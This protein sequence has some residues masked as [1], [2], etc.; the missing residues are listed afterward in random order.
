M[1]G[2]HARHLTWFSGHDCTAHFSTESYYSFDDQRNSF[3]IYVQL[4]CAACPHTQ[5]SSGFDPDSGARQCVDAFSP[6]VLELTLA[7]LTG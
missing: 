3:Q 1:R 4:Q 5:A 6:F 7:S 2:G